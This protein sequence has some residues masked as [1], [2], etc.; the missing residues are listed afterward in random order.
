MYSERKKR[1]AMLDRWDD[2]EKAQKWFNDSWVRPSEEYK[3]SGYDSIE[4]GC[5]W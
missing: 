4:G 5:Y 3:V 2:R 1:G